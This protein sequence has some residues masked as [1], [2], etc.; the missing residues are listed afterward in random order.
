MVAVAGAACT[1]AEQFGVVLCIAGEQSFEG[2]RL[3][4]VAV[5]TMRAALVIRTINI[6]VAAPTAVPFIVVARS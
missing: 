4:A 5:V 1:E 6:A 2:G 3:W